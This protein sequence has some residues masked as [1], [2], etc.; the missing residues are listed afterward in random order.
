MRW[1]K[2][3]NDL[4]DFLSYMVS[5]AP[6]EF[7]EED[8]LSSDDQMNLEK[9][10]KILNSSME[11]VKEKISNSDQL[12]KLQSLLDKS[13]AAYTNGEDVK[14]AHI[15][16]EFEAIVFKDNKKWTLSVTQ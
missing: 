4:L 7:P 15:L 1:I 2:N 9:A 10:F 13:N 8:Y 3:L 5:D 11:F 16:Q 6:D 12:K 14:G